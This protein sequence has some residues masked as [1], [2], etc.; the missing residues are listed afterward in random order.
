M[1]QGDKQDDSDL[2]TELLR[3]FVVFD[4]DSSGTISPMEL[5]QVLIS[6]GQKYTSDE[7]SEMIRQVDLDGDGLINCESEWPR[8]PLWS[9]R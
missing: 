6:Q 4:K 2:H 7:I 5:R 3:A 9:P 1:T 8:R